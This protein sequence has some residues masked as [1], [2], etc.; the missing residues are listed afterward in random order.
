M[1]AHAQQATSSAI[2]GPLFVLKMIASFGVDV[3]FGQ[4]GKLKFICNSCFPAETP[5]PFSPTPGISL[6]LETIRIASM[7][8]QSSVQFLDTCELSM[9][10]TKTS[11]SSSSLS[12]SSL[13][14]SE[15]QHTL[16][17]ATERLVTVLS[18]KY[19]QWDTLEETRRWFPTC[20]E[21]M[22]ALF[23]LHPYP[24][25]LL[26]RLVLSLF[27]S[28]KNSTK[29]CSSTVTTCRLSRFLFLLGQGLLGL[30]LYTERMATLS[31]TNKEKEKSLRLTSGK[32]KEKEISRSGVKSSKKKS[33]KAE[34]EHGGNGYEEDE[35]VDAMEE[36]MGMAAAVDA[37]DEK[38]TLLLL[39]LSFCLSV[40]LSLTLSN[41]LTI[42]PSI[43]RDS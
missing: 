18:D 31:K 17:A 6:D 11:S 35:G 28:W 5:D 26:C 32:D 16:L 20:E 2:S 34:E 25:E 24:E 3:G 38:V 12:S 43:D 27:L 36:E 8:F 4:V 1:S 30:L 13:N 33:S 29:Y 14:L 39:S 15:I 37:D 7:C 42:P 10:T 19:S 23:R 9:L 41:S 21:A 22:Y 40:S